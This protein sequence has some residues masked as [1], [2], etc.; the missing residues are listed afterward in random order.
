[1]PDELNGENINALARKATPKKTVF[2]F[3]ADLG[4]PLIEVI[5][6][7]VGPAFKRKLFTLAQLFEDEGK[8]AEKI[9]PSLP[10]RSPAQAGAFGRR[11]KAAARWQKM[12]AG[13]S[14]KA[15]VSTA[16]SNGYAVGDDFA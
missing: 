2:E 16:V 7:S 10:R 11:I 3:T 9:R 1:M 14:G 13:V 4:P 5:L 12:V 8:Q 15:A 6:A